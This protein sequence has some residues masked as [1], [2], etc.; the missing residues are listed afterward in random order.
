MKLILPKIEVFPASVS[1]VNAHCTGPA[2]LTSISKNWEILFLSVRVNDFVKSKTDFAY[3]LA[4]INNLI[5]RNYYSAFPKPT[6]RSNYW[7]RHGIFNNVR[8]WSY[9][10][11]KTDSIFTLGITNLNSCFRLS[12]STVASTKWRIV[13]ILDKELVYYRCGGRKPCKSLYLPPR[14]IF[15]VGMI[16]L[17]SWISIGEITIGRGWTIEGNVHEPC[18]QILGLFLTPSPFH[19]ATG[20]SI[21]GTKEWRLVFEFSSIL[22][23]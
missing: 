21:C 22:R 16:A 15:L 6:N 4:I 5:C 11:Y 12:Y 2:I 1:Q 19:S 3:I 13:S 8:V 20:W 18:G 14:M 10:R 23:I 9:E 17:R 7:I